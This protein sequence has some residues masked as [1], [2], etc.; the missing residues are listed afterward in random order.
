MLHLLQASG[1]PPTYLATNA[2]TSYQPQSWVPAGRVM[3]LA[4]SPSSLH[5][6][7][8][9]QTHSR[10]HRESEKGRKLSCLGA[11][12]ASPW[13]AMHLLLGEG[14]FCRGRA[15]VWNSVESWLLEGSWQQ[16]QAVEAG[17]EIILWICSWPWKIRK[18]EVGKSQ[19]RAYILL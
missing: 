9:V 1:C 19:K 15:W 7:H 18:S 13:P 2:G 8:H 11:S 12:C 6:F 4:A 17:H 5:F 14:K 3:F 10:S 16:C